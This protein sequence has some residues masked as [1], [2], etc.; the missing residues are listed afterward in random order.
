MCLFSLS[1]TG[2]S[3]FSKAKQ[4]LYLLFPL[5]PSAGRKNDQLRSAKPLVKLVPVPATLKF[6]KVEPYWKL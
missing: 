1:N 6:L 5:F 2:K 3:E 4:T